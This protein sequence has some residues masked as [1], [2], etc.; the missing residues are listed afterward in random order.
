MA[1]GKKERIRFDENGNEIKK[2]TRYYSTK[3]EK[4]VAST[5]NGRQTKNSGATPFDSGDVTTDDCLIE[6]KTKMSHSNSISI[7]KEWL[8]KIRDEALFMGKPHQALFFNFGEGELNYV[9]ISEEY[10]KE[11]RDQ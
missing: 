8:L 4:K 3:Q 5:F 6:C 9:I 10:F 7:K 2:P 1:V 11:L